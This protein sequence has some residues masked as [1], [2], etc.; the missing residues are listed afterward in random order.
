MTAIGANWI[1]ASG[2]R[3]QLAAESA[4]LTK[5]AVGWQLD[6]GQAPVEGAEIRL[7]PV[8][9]QP[10]GGMCDAATPPDDQVYRQ[11]ADPRTICALLCAA[12]FPGASRLLASPS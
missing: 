12:R 8:G 3:P 11:D 4:T 6:G 1:Y 10:C 9:L 2:H 7:R 5:L